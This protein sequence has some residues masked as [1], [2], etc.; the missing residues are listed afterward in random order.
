MDLILIQGRKLTFLFLLI[1]VSILVLMDLIL[2][3]QKFDIEPK[4]PILFQSL[5]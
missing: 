4:A 1:N 5:F 3:L 2:I